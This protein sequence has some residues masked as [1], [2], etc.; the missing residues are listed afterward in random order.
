MKRSIAN[1]VATPKAGTL[2]VHAMAGLLAIAAAMFGPPDA[3]AQT[4][5]AAEIANIESRLNVT[6]QQKSA[7][8]PVMQQSMQARR[9]VFKKHGVDLN[10]GKKPGLFGLMALS[11]EMKEISAWARARLSKILDPIQL[12]EYDKIVAEQTEIVRRILLR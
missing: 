9:A 4:L 1:R 2:V 7:M 10:S 12:Q 6:P 11:G 8:T 5:S 3:Y